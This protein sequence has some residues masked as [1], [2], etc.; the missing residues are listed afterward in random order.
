MSAKN[1]DR[2]INVRGEIIIE[3]PARLIAETDVDCVVG[4]MKGETVDEI[5][6][7]G[8]DEPVVRDEIGRASCRER[9]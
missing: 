5:V 6:A 3:G 1:S 4:S 8:F 9:V 7:A 2:Q